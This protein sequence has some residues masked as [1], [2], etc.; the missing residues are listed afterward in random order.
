MPDRFNSAPADKSEIDPPISGAPH[1]FEAASALHRNGRFAEAQ[2]VLERLLEAQP[3]HFEAL[4][5]SALIAAQSGHLRRAVE[6]FD[7]AL[8]VRPDHAA[9]HCN[10]GVALAELDDFA[11]ALSSYDR[12]ISLK[13]DYAA[14]Y[15]NRGNAQKELGQLE[16]ALSSFDRAVA[17][18][19]D[20]A[21]AYV[22]RGAVLKDLGRFEAALRSY[23]QAIGLRSNLPEAH[24][25]RGMVL[26]ELRQWEAA[27]ASYNQAIACKADYADAYLN[28]GVLLAEL[29]RLEL[30]VANYDRAIAINPDFSAAYVNR[31]MAS[32]LAGNFAAGWID[33]EW[34]WKDETGTNAKERRDFRQPLW[35]G[36]QSLAGKTILIY[37]EQGLGDTLQFCRFVKPVAELGARVIL[38]VQKP[39]ATLLTGLT[40]VSHLVARGGVLPEY[41]YQCPL[42]SLPLAF[43]TRLESIPAATRYV[44]VDATQAAQW[45]TK[46]PSGPR[47][48]LMWSGN[49]MN[50]RD[51][52]RSV[53]LAELLRYLPAEFHYVS[54]QK[55]VR[56]SDAQALRSNA[57]MMNFADDQ[58]DFSDAAA[59]CECMDLVISVDTSV[60]H[61]SGALGKETWILLPFSPD[62]RWLLGRVDSPWYP[63]VK[64][65]RQ[66]SIDDWSGVLRRVSA[67]L[68]QKFGAARTGDPRRAAALLGKAVEID[69][70]HATVF[71][72]RGNALCELGQ[73]EAA[74]ACYDRVIALKSDHADAHYNRG[75]VLARLR[76]PGAALAGFDRA[77]EISPGFAE[78][79]FNRGN[80]LQELE[81]WDAALASYGRAIE[82]NPRFAEAYANRGA[83][84]N[85]LN[86]IDAALA[87]YEQAI[88]INGEYAEA[89]CNRGLLLQEIKEW[90][91][92]LASCDK[93]IGLKADYAE[94]YVN[95]SFVRLLRADFDNGWADYEWRWKEKNGPNSADTRRFREPLWRGQEFAAGAAILVFCEQ[96]LG[97][98]LQFC[99]YVKTLSQLGFRV[100][101]EVQPPLAGL[102]ANL[103]GASQVLTRGS[104]LPLFAWQC[105]L[106]SLPLALK[107][108]LQSIPATRRYLD[109]DPAKLVRWQAALGPSLKPRVGL[110][111]SGS[112][113]NRRDRHRSIG[114][115]ELLRHLPV[116]PQYVSLQ[117]E[118]REA[119]PQV[120]RSYPG[121][122]N[123]AADQADFS[124]AAALCDCMDLVISVDT[125]IAHL[126]AALG[127]ETWILLPFSADWRWLLDR[128][129]SPWYPT[130]KLYRQERSGDWS[131]VL[132]RVS[133][134]LRRRFAAAFLEI[135]AQ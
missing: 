37:S 29:N 105:P 101:L 24:S 120:L 79:H 27:L 63:T 7:E 30:A 69:P 97:D 3:R 14:A 62:W 20:L 129:D 22:N 11:G 65:Y 133:G 83:L 82:S 87:S 123:F 103:E 107:T 93:A 72:N 111:W 114:L 13:P 119:D 10:R 6:L 9:S 32:L 17:I 31:S 52:Q 112:P 80:L 74:L 81:Q 1:E 61:L 16:A 68:V 104:A 94:A 48:G 86:R 113:S 116:G 77:I 46:L 76:Q 102:L 43:K 42:L 84:Y 91:A 96:G 60:A 67:D 70:G 126:S 45:R 131:G 127:R 36:Q 135:T 59:L 15:S 99:R 128:D 51:R 33:Y 47:I 95:R 130:A 26:K 55:E 109:V 49:A 106:L 18:K 2:A 34:R 118:L 44:H 121:I 73:W 53:A 117:K 56:E 132:E 122:T 92:A 66:E 38:E 58:K 124:D 21:E 85:R 125:S 54:L 25:N 71:F 50:R 41:D 4:F 64:L 88:A 115:A 39:L 19:P 108:N 28:R 78:A 110:M 134:D 5:L 8:G 75:T 35:L 100:I 89:Y 57:D 40:G 12:A 23:D 90:D 98:T